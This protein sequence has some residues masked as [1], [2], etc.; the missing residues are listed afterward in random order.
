MCGAILFTAYQVV[1]IFSPVFKCNK[2]LF[3]VP[4]SAYFVL[5]SHLSGL[6]AYWFTNYTSF[7]KVG[8]VPGIYIAASISFTD[9][10]GLIILALRIYGYWREH[11]GGQK[12]K[13]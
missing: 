11:K 4:I 8:V 12:T 2:V 5:P 3:L 6:L 10:S 9:I 1:L 7:A 13:F